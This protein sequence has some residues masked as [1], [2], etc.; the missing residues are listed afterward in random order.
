MYHTV[1]DFASSFK[2]AYDV[3]NMKLTFELLNV[4]GQQQ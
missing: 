1:S 3:K 4:S 2:F